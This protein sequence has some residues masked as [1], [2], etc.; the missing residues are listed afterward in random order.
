MGSLNERNPSL[1]VETAPETS[2]PA[3]SGKPGFDAIVIGGG[4]AGL[5]A[6]YMLQRDGL[7]V[8]VLEAGRI[9]SGVTG[10][11]T[12]K[13]TALHG[14]IYTDL[15]QR[16]GAE[17]AGMYASANAEA[18]EIVRRV[19]SAERIECALEV[20][21]AYTY[22]DTAD[23]AERV[24]EEAEACRE[25]GLPAEATYDVPL[26]FPTAGAV[27]L[28]DQAQFHPRE[29]CLGL[30]AA[31]ERHGGKIFERTQVSDVE[32]KERVCHVE[33]EHGTL[34]T[35]NVVV[36]THLPFMGDGSFFAKT[37]PKRSYAM[38]F[39]GGPAIDGMF[40]SCEEPVRSL[41]SATAGGASWLIVGGENHKVG[42]DDDTEA[43]YAALGAWAAERLGLGEA[44]HRWS[45][46][47]Y[48]SVDGIPYVG[49][50]T[51]DHQRVFVATGFR[52]WGFTNATAGAV[53]I[54]DAIAGR[55]NPWAKAF[56]ATRKR[57]P[58]AA[59]RLLAENLNV[60]KEL[61][62]GKLQINGV[63]PS[64]LAPGEGVI[65]NVD[66]EMVACARDEDGT[67]HAVSP[68][69]T[70]MGCRVAWNTAERTWDCPC[71]GSRF[72]MDGEV[73]QGPATQPLKPP[74]IGA[75]R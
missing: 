10:Y 14:L 4:I 6:A 31:I 69:C 36:A 70:H 63:S 72:T 74:E 49:R 53:I 44:T 19:V 2:Y 61:I 39:Q 29:Y 48:I 73:I 42:Q 58:Q 23:G 24:R 68:D 32:E 37:A 38:A 51:A 45:A 28:R 54:A 20:K 5:T 27:V 40:I 25:L 11:T 71:H 52:K 21:D 34:S 47:D 8:A 50:L 30:A 7:D 56:D 41:R 66:G 35:K 46:Q 3:L 22:A 9:A 65:T 1:W 59:K 43:R 17:R 67:L 33:T 15:L 60:A 18:V 12:A 16:H 62:G 26:P 57:L 75:K 55:D 13:V 64:E